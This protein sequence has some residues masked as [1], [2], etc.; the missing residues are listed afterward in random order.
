MT[1]REQSLF[2]TVNTTKTG[3]VWRAV[4]AG[5]VNGALIAFDRAQKELWDEGTRGGVELCNP[6]GEVI[7]RCMFTARKRVKNVL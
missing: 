5:D 6:E 2:W 1:E 3:R 4:F 7:K